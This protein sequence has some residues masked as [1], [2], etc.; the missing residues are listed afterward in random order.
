VELHADLAALV[1]GSDE[2][3]ENLLAVVLAKVLGLLERRVP[4]KPLAAALLYLTVQMA[5]E[6]DLELLVNRRQV[7]P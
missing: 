3:V 6:R 2:R 1:G 4:V 7:I 5:F